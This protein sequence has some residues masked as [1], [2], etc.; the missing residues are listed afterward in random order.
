MIVMQI[1]YF[2]KAFL[3]NRLFNFC[4]SKALSLTN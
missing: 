2:S 4:E 1:L 3:F